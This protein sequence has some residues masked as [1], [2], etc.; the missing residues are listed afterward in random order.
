MTH[1]TSFGFA[2][3]FALLAASGCSGSDDPDQT[4]SRLG[5]S[6]DCQ[7]DEPD[8][9]PPP[10]P[11]C[12]GDAPDCQPPPPPPCDG[13]APDCQPPPPPPCDGDEPDCQPLMEDNDHG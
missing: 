7:G 12:D 8:C 11:P 2:C 6:V 3:L 4:G 5:E 10:S 1:R 9:Q 13:D